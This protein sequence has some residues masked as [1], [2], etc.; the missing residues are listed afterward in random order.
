MNLEL[1]TGNSIRRVI[2]LAIL[3]LL[4]IGGATVSFVIIPKTDSKSAYRPS[5][6]PRDKREQIV[7]AL[8]LH[9]EAFDGR[10]PDQ[11]YGD[12]LIRKVWSKLDLPRTAGHSPAA[13]FAHLTVLQQEEPSFRY[14]GQRALFGDGDSVLLHWSTQADTN[15]VVFGDL[16]CREASDADL[17]SILNPW[18]DIAAKCVVRVAGGSGVVISPDGL[19]VTANH[20]VPNG[21]SATI[22][23]YNGQVASAVVVDRS[24]RLDVALLRCDF[25][26]EVPFIEMETDPVEKGEALWTIGYPQGS[27][28]PRIRETSSYRYV[29][30]EL[31]M[32]HDRDILGGDSGG[33]ILNR[34]GKLVGVVLGPA[35]GHLNYIRSASCVGIRN[36]W[37]DEFNQTMT[38]RR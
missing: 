34:N 29:L 17:A 35:D 37:P 14:Y 12:R 24:V 31:I 1:A 16:T 15:T 28:A 18:K 22:P 6:T 25:K 11:L 20:V 2:W 26:D 38:G 32:T 4:P 23:Y 10:F 30:D 5:L 9:A 13:G 21:D 27:H 3:V 33:A 19:I 8:K 7:D 36:R